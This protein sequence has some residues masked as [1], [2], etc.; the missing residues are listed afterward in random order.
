MVK[1][2]EDRFQILN[3]ID[4]TGVFIHP[5]NTVKDTLGCPLLGYLL[6]S[7]AGVVGNSGAAV[8][9]FESTMNKRFTLQI[10]NLLESMRH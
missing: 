6:D 7:K 2:G 1:R 3:V 4:R 8:K 5:G 9:A 10:T